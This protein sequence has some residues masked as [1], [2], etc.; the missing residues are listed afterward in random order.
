MYSWKLLCTLKAF[1]MAVSGCFSFEIEHERLLVNAIF[2]KR[3]LIVFNDDTERG[4]GLMHQNQN[5][6][7]LKRTRWNISGTRTA[8]IVLQGFAAVLGRRVSKSVTVRR[9]LGRRCV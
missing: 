4:S 1:R 8:N 3:T 6:V 5:N 7:I 9:K 2:F